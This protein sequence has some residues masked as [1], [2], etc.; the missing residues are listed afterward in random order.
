MHGPWIPK[1]RVARGRKWKLL[2]PL[3]GWAQNLQCHLDHVAFG[4]AV[5]EPA[6]IPMGGEINSAAQGGE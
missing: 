2:S 5:T 4:K 6:R 3:G 1:V